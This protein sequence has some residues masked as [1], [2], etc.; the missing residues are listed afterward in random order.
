MAF[1]DNYWGTGVC[2]FANRDRD[3]TM[4]TYLVVG[5]AS[6]SSN[7]WSITIIGMLARCCHPPRRARKRSADRMPQ[8]Y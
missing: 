1:G 2:A 4:S 8:Q 7:Y 5:S 6:R 3:Q